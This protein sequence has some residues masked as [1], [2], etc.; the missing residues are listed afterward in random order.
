MSLN[1]T[2]QRSVTLS[3]LWLSVNE[4]AG[5]KH[6]GGVAWE[7]E[8][9]ELKVFIPVSA[10][11]PGNWVLTLV[12]WHFDD[13]IAHFLGTPENPEQPVKRVEALPCTCIRT[14]NYACKV[15]C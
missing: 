12:E 14:Q 7:V 8:P 11:T 1:V 9:E 13:I 10:V 4:G 15:K 3:R 2:T 6:L 5:K